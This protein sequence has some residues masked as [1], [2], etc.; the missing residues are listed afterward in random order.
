MNKL[1]ALIAATSMVLTAAYALFLYARVCFGN[2]KSWTNYSDLSRREFAALL[3]F[4][5]LSLY[6][7]IVPSLL[8]NTSH[9]SI[10]NI[11]LSY[12]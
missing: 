9:A 6:V 12:N 11:L 7:G 4:V 1:V 3:P 8:L 5:I 10:A 2:T